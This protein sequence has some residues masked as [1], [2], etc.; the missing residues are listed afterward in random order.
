MSM[1]ATGIIGRFEM[2][3]SE[4]VYPVWPLFAVLTFLGIAG[5]AFLAYRLRWH[6]VALRHKFI[7][8]AAV[9]LILAVTIPGGYFLVSPIFE[10]SVACEVSPL[11]GAGVGSEKCEDA[12]AI[13][14]TGGEDAAAS[15]GA[16]EDG[17]PGGADFE[18]RLVARGTV[19]GADT[20][21]F[22]EGDALLIEAGPGEY[23]LR[24]ENFSVRN[25]PDLFVYLSPNPGGYDG[26]ALNLG[27][28]KATDGA[29]NYEIP[30]GT[31]VSQFKS[32]IVW[33]RAF[34]V[35]FAVAELEEV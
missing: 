9:V 19:E 13:A 15:P 21:H 11:A 17:A 2:F 18:A 23:I 31:D 28:L 27:E 7:S 10:R 22:G 20:F 35:L 14:E 34:S 5:A 33:C 4:V 3:F 24:F 32:A 30:P 16:G 8:G 6:E 25:G 26:S 29:F 12:V 1:L